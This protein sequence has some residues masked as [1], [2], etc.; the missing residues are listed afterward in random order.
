MTLQKPEAEV[1]PH[2]DIGLSI[3]QLKYHQYQQIQ[4][5]FQS[6]LEQKLIERFVV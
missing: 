1:Q 2:K 4:Q 5:T 6:V 3:N